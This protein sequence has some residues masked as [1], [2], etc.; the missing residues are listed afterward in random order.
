MRKSAYR[1][2]R[3]RIPIT[4]SMSFGLPVSPHAAHASGKP[5]RNHSMAMRW[6]S[7]WL[8]LMEIATLSPLRLPSVAKPLAITY[9]AA[10]LPALCAGQPRI[11]LRPSMTS[12][13][14]PLKHATDR[15]QLL[16]HHRQCACIWH[17]VRAGY[18]KHKHSRWF[19]RIHRNVVK[20]R[21]RGEDIC[22]CSGGSES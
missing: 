15:R 11:L 17:G 4:G 5:P 8:S 13:H 12:A 22:G 21:V 1:R 14:Q 2:Y 18:R 3:I 6:P 9:G 16:L 20:L 19:D 7:S 10:E